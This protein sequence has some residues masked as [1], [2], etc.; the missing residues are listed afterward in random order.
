MIWPFPI[1]TTLT[2]CSRIV[3]GTLP[4][5]ASLPCSHMHSAIIQLLPPEESR[6]NDHQP[7]FR[8]HQ[9]T[10]IG[11]AA[12]GACCCLEDNKVVI[13]RVSAKLLLLQQLR[14]PAPAPA[15]V[16]LHGLWHPDLLDLGFFGAT[17]IIM[18][19]P[20]HLLPGR[21]R[22]FCMRLYNINQLLSLP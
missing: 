10:V 22:S 7:R 15:A 13:R 8:A 14:A 18:K 5:V 1:L 9:Q 17:C 4:S 3:I 6:N 12:A 11:V 2:I 21:F 20:E 16:L 19:L